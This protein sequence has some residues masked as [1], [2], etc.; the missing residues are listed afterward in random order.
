MSKID[1]DVAIGQVDNRFQAAE[2]NVFAPKPFI[3]DRLHVIFTH[4]MGL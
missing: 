2:R 3:A 4:Q 1:P